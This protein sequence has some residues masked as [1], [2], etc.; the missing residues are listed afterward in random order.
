MTAVRPFAHVVAAEG[1]VFQV[2]QH[3][4]ALGV[5]VDGARERGA[6]AD[7]VRPAL[8]RVDVV[9]E[10]EDVLHVA[11]VVLEG[12][13]DDDLVPLARMG[14]GGRVE[15]GL[16]LVQV[17]HEG[18]DAPLVLEVVLLPRPLVEE[19][20]PDA[21]VEERE[22]AEPLRERVEVVV[23]RLEDRGV[24]LPVDGR[25]RTV[26]RPQLLDVARDHAALVALAVLLAAAIDVDFEPLGERVHHRH[27][28]PME[29]ARDLVAVVVEL[30]ARVERGHHDLEGGAVLRRMHIDRNAAAVVHHGHARVLVDRDQDLGAEP[31]ER[32]VHRVVDHLVDEM[33]EAALPGR[34]DVHGGTLAHALQAL[35]DLD[36]PG[37][38]RVPAFLGRR[39]SPPLI[40][41]LV[42][43]R[44]PPC[45]A[46][47]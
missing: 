9:H 12:E 15:D 13:L 16:V 2:L 19:L 5:V 10:G 34:P 43:V 40:A 45:S 23:D 20:D 37:V 42:Q 3:P 8:H 18:D 47:A 7:E 21:L 4:L 30:P 29:P 25:S 35:Q 38:V 22:L 44:L 32:L 14:D 31:G 11:V 28:H 26:G 41:R 33:V 39:Q 36:V 27:A 46:S 1:E 17:L 24:G 6:E